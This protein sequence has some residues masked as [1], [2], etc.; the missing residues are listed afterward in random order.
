[1]EGADLKPNKNLTLR[2]VCCESTEATGDGVFSLGTA[3][4]CCYN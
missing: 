3:V 2:P 1:M 4:C